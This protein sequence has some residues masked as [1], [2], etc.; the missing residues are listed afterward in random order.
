MR[1]IVRQERQRR[2]LRKRRKRR[3]WDN[4]S[5]RREEDKRRGTFLLAGVNKS[6]VKK[7]KD[8]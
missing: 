8:V 6:A 5:V 1:N 3:I 7:K 2:K 4:E